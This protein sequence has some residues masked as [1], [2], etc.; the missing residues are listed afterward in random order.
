MVTVDT[1]LERAASTGIALP[2]LAP[3]RAR[4]ATAFRAQGL[5]TPR[6]EDWRYTSLS[7]LKQ[8]ELE[9]GALDAAEHP[10]VDGVARV[11]V[12][13]GKWRVEVAPGVTVASLLDATPDELAT[14]TDLAGTD[15]LDALNTAAIAEGCVVR[16]EPGTRCEVPVEL[17]YTGLRHPRTV[18]RVGSGAQLHLIEHWVG[19]QAAYLV[20]PVTEVQLETGATLEL[21]ELQN[22]GPAAFH[23]GSIHANVSEGATLRALSFALGGRVHRK[24]FDALL[25]ERSEVSFSG[26]YVASEGQLHDHQTLMHHRGAHAHSAQ[27]F[28]GIIDRGGRGA[29]TGKVLVAAGAQKTDSSQQVRNLLLADDAIANA[30]PQLEILADDVK[31]SHGAT[32]GQ[33]DA[34]ALFFLRSRGLDLAQARALLTWAFASEQVERLPEGGLRDYITGLLHERLRALRGEA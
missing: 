8:S 32:V 10:Q 1:L 18:V 25:E 33:L 17:L 34:E 7:A 31:C 13:P 5:P 16:V 30:R 20:N 3:M 28:K 27:V 15:P 23:L 26:V 6:H 4:A 21:T 19:N 14:I 9:A 11:V 24:R 22:E 29:F 12:R 2:V